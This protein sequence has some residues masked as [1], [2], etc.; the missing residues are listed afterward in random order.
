[1]LGQFGT[2][3]QLE[4]GE[5]GIYYYTIVH[6]VAFKSD[7]SKNK[8]QNRKPVD[9]SFT[10]MLELQDTNELKGSG[11]LLYTKDMPVMYLSNISTSSGVV[12][13]MCGTATCIVPDSEG[14]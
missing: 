6:T 7:L 12:N 8:K 2:G 11:F 4:I 9:I 14:M 1:M 3:A 10:K 13:R 5:R